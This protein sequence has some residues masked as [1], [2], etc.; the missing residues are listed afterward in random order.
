[1]SITKFH[2]LNKK[3]LK[4]RLSDLKQHPLK[5]CQLRRDDV[6]KNTSI[7]SPLTKPLFT[8]SGFL[9]TSGLAQ[10]QVPLGGFRGK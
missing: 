10:T 3:D 6:R 8:V 1:M 7:D 9:M 5:I 2:R 4:R